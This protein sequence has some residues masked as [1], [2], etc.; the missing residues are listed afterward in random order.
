MAQDRHDYDE[1]PLRVHV[2]R[3]AC[4]TV[5]ALCGELDYFSVPR[6]RRTLADLVEPKGDIVFDLARLSFVDTAGI[7]C[8]VSAAAR[9]QASGGRSRLVSPSPMAARLIRLLGLAE[10]LGLSR[11]SRREQ[12]RARGPHRHTPTAPVRAPSEMLG[13][14]GG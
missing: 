6:L 1:L 10:L 14:G 12:R 3:T 7:H 9:V 13:T 11:P 4:H 2:E 5:V 8:L